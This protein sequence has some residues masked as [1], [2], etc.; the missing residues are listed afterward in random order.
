MKRK[1]RILLGLLLNLL[2]VQIVYGYETY[3]YNGVED[4]L[5]NLKG[6]QIK[7][8]SIARY[9]AHYDSIEL[10]KRLDAE[11][12]A[13][14]LGTAHGRPASFERKTFYWHFLRVTR[15]EMKQDALD[16]LGK[17][18]DIIII[19]AAPGW[20][21]FP[22]TVANAIIKNVESGTPLIVFG[23]RKKFFEYLSRRDQHLEDLKLGLS[24]F[25]PVDEKPLFTEKYYRYGQGIIANIANPIDTRR[26]YLVSQSMNRLHEQYK[27]RRIANV[28]FKLASGAIE[29]EIESISL[30]NENTVKIELQPA[31]AQRK[32]AY[33]IHDKNCRTVFESPKPVT[34]ESGSALF[35]IGLPQ[36]SNGE[37]SADVE[38]YS[39]GKLSDWISLL[40]TIDYNARIS[41]AELENDTLYDTDALDLNLAYSEDTANCS[42]VLKCEDTF[43]RVYFEETYL[44]PPEKIT[45][46]LP[47]GSLSVLNHIRL[48]LLDGQNVLDT[49]NVEFTLPQKAKKRDFHVLLWGAG[50]ASARSQ[51]YLK[52]IYDN[53]I[54]GSCNTGYTADT[55]RSLA[56]F[57]L[58]GIP[59]TTI[60]AGRCIDEHLF[61][62]EW[63]ESMLKRCRIAAKAYL[64]YAGLGYTLGDEIYLS[65]FKPEGRFSNSPRVMNQFHAYLERQY[66]TVGKL[67]EQWGTS[68][69]AFRDIQF[70]KEKDL[71]LD[72]NNPSA[73]FDYRMFLTEKFMGLHYIFRDEIRKTDHNAMVGYDGTEQYSSYDGYDWFQYTRGL[74]VNNVYSNYIIKAGYPNK[75]F[76]GMCIRSFTDKNNVRGGWANNVD[77]EWGLNYLPWY[78]TLC[79]FNSVWWWTGTFL[80]PETDAFDVDLTPTPTF[81]RLLN[82]SNEVQRG[83]ATLIR[84]ATL[85]FSPIAIHY[86]QNN[87]HAST[88]SSGIGNHVNNLGLYNEFW[89]KT[90]LYGDNPDMKE[91]FE[92]ADSL[93]HYAVSSKN[94]ITLLHDLG[95]QPRMLAKQ[96]I[97]QGML[98][99]GR[100]KVLVLPFVESLSRKEI[101]EI[102]KFVENGGFLIADYRTGIRDEHG[103][104]HNKSPLDELFGIRRS[105]F[106]LE[107]KYSRIN[108]DS[109]SVGYK[110]RYHHFYGTLNGL[111]YN[112]NISLP[113]YDPSATLPTRGGQAAGYNEAGVPVYIFNQYGEGYT[114]FLNTDINEYF[115]SRRAGTESSYKNIF[116]NN[117]ENLANLKAPYKPM[118]DGNPA[119]HTE[120]FSYTDAG[121]KYAGLIRDFCVQDHSE[122]EMEL[123]LDQ[124]SHLYSVTDNKYLGHTDT[125]KSTL[126]SGRALIFAQCPYQIKGIALSGNRKVKR[127]RDYKLDINVL[128]NVPNQQIANHTVNIEVYNP[129]GKNLLYLNDN[130][131]LEGGTG[132]YSMPIAL[133]DIKGEWTIKVREVISGKQA[134]H[135]FKIY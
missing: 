39:N 113:T 98:N 53:N 64:K 7:V 49:K 101:D 51:A 30:Q 66:E 40:F 28:I 93:G 104:L 78:L 94:F 42:L 114:L 62:D 3:V 129:V 54:A 109:V 111:F 5:S 13:I 56:E 106:E 128:A 82:A 115:N 2:M 38:V 119:P 96:Q 32:V 68:Y 63:I 123:S 75:L 134:I 86:S 95:Y 102:Y 21:V 69:A 103:K 17:A 50:G 52:A 84:N 35:Y 34:L 22:E 125:I 46:P 8:L 110:G 117:I 61:N 88:L 14:R 57:N 122:Y 58:T 19:G 27:Y 116:R 92:G 130:L 18:Y 25:D 60:L 105:S 97:E 67:N 132:E 127:G 12:T 24:K 81:G 23:R 99:A 9:P 80:G 43:G 4:Q 71:F 85:D 15:D 89:F 70:E 135:K 47:E 131:Y 133:N 87:F 33:S 55:A 126:S 121:I 76:N 83:I 120:I 1:S 74:E 59:Y 73:W 108:I 36:L 16:A 65:A 79:Q 29:A 26:G 77:Y 20:D 118:V 90:P 11:I 72:N 37:Y 48:F 45:M 107:K 31:E 6:G 91:L 100:Y 112:P 10:A 44:K 124:K 41:M